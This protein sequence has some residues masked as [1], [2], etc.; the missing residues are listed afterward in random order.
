MVIDHL[1]FIFSPLLV[2][3][4]IL[5]GFP[6]FDDG[7]NITNLPKA[8][9]GKGKAAGMVEGIGPAAPRRFSND[10]L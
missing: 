7:H 10:R 2:R 5:C 8:A 6:F 4:L 1:P 3:V 9:M